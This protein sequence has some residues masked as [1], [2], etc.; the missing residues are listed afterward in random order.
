MQRGV[1]RNVKEGRQQTWEGLLVA[2]R[3]SAPNGLATD[4][5][6]VGV[7]WEQIHQ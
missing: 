6:Q 3:Y 7:I 2:S 5:L 4:R 1:G